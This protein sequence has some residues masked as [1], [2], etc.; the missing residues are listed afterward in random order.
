MVSKDAEKIFKALC[1]YK[2]VL[3]YN[4]TDLIAKMKLS[5]KRDVKITLIREAVCFRLII[6]LKNVLL[7]Y[8]IT[9]YT[10]QE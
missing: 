2:T 10:I 5:D 8:F 7:Q 4:S 3:L 9:D 1:S 6:E